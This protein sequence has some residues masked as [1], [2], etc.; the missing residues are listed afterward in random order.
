MLIISKMMDCKLYVFIKKLMLAAY[1]H[2]LK[3]QVYRYNEE[4]KM[5]EFGRSSISDDF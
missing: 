5:T 2:M 3:V 1:K 4:Q